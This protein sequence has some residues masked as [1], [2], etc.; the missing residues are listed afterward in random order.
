MR[1]KTNTRLITLSQGSFSLKAALDGLTTNFI[2]GGTEEGEQM[3]SNA[4]RRKFTQIL[5]GNI[6]HK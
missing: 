1:L 5:P 4:Q 6:K 2:I 3:E